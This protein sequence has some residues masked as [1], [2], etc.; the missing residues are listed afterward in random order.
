MVSAT[1]PSVRPWKPPRNATTPG[2]PVTRRASLTAPS[3]TSV[4]AL[5]KNTVSKG[6][7]SAADSSAARR[8]VGSAYPAP[9]MCTSL[10]TWRWMAAVTAGWPWPRTVVAMPQ[11]KS[12]YEEPSAAYRRCPS[13][14]TNARSGFRPS[15][16]DMWSRA[17]VTNS[18]MVCVCS[19]AGL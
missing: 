6:S 12:R 4:P 7:G 13:P 10:S 3:M 18:G 16:G 11:T 5:E 14:R 2:R 9:L 15:T 1:D 19:M 17:S 8:A